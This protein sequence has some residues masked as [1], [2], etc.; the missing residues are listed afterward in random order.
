MS[1]I[2]TLIISVENNSKSVYLNS[3]LLY[4]N[5]AKEHTILQ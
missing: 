2:I 4:G 3:Q 5:S 1:E